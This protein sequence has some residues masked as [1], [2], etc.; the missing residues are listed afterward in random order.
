MLLSEGSSLPPA[1]RSHF[2]SIGTKKYRLFCY[3]IN[4]CGSGGFHCCNNLTSLFTQMSQFIEK[5]EIQQSKHGFLGNSHQLRQQANFVPC[6]S[7]LQAKPAEVFIIIIIRYVLEPGVS[8]NNTVTVT[9]SSWLLLVSHGFDIL[10]INP[11][12]PLYVL[13]D[14]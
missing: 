1:V 13:I 10:Y 6:L 3:Y 2:Q 9:Q 8:L 4:N 11:G 7:Y 5:S 12:N 14:L